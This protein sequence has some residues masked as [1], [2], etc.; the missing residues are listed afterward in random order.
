V[1]EAIRESVRHSR[2]RKDFRFLN[3]GVTIICKSYDLPRGGRREFIVHYPGIVNGLQTVIALYN[4][5]KD[6]SEQEKD[7]FKQNCSVLGQR[8]K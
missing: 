1:N 6:L 4:A 2:S 7:D 8:Q 3:N 5:S